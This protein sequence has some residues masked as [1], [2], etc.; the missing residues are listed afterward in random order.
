[1]RDDKSFGNSLDRSN[2]LAHSRS[3]AFGESIRC[4]IMY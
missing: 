4:P 1:L 2:S 3:V